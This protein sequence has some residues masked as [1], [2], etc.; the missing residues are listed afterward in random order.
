MELKNPWAL[1][2]LLAWAPMV[3][4]YIRRERRGRPALR[5]S[6]LSL[7]RSPGVSARVEMRHL[8]FILR[9]IGVGL[10]VVALARPRKGQ[11]NEEV[12]TQGVD[13]MLVLDVSTSM[14]ALDFKPQNRLHVSKETIKAFIAKR[15]HD[16]MGL[17]VFAAR[18]YTKCPLTLD[19]DIL[20]R[21]ADDID[22]GAVED[23]TAIGTAVATAA[24][25]LLNSNAKSK[26][27][28]LCTDGANNRGDIAPGAAAK[29]AAELGIKIYTIGVGREGKVPYPFEVRNPWTGN[30]Q[31]RVEMID[32][33]LDEQSLVNIA[34]TSGGQ[35]FRAQNAE[36]LQQIYDLIDKLE[37]TEIKTM[38]YTTYDERF[39]A[40]LVAGAVLLLIE[41]V[42][43]HTVF[44]RI[45]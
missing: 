11:I 12:S 33:D 2:L 40:W 10:L 29:A 6:D 26:V 38:S 22:F 13:I 36:E 30:V 19:Y 45:P 23:G 34:N 8:V 15:K 4:V 39:F 28:I 16:R 27:M 25:R 18:S 42:L 1:L 21:F 5:F 7:V 32:S 14:K 24:N 9:L 43:A 37:K 3:W 17:V 41:V 44:R 35:Y 31:T 20:T